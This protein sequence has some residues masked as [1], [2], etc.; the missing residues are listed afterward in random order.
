[1]IAV[2]SPNCCILHIE[3]DQRNSKFNFF[4]RDGFLLL[5]LFFLIKKKLT[6]AEDQQGLWISW[7][8]SPPLLVGV[9]V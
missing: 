3:T 1:M 7:R 9:S 4:W 6:H 8:S 2:E 5:L